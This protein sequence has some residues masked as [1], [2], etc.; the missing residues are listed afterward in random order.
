[1]K[2]LEEGRQKI[3]AARQQSHYLP[4]QEDE[5]STYSEKENIVCTVQIFNMEAVGQMSKSY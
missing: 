4:L 3:E 1:M 2:E 5:K